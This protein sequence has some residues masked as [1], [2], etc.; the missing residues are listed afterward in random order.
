[1]PPCRHMSHSLK[2]LLQNDIQIQSAQSEKKWKWK[3]NKMRRI[4]QCHSTQ[5]IQFLWL[6][7]YNPQ[8]RARCWKQTVHKLISQGAW[9]H[10]TDIQSH[11]GIQTLI[12][13]FINSPPHCATPL[14]L[15]TFAFLAPL[16]HRGGPTSRISFQQIL[17]VVIGC[18]HS[19]VSFGPNAVCSLSLH[20][21]LFLKIKRRE[22]MCFSQQFCSP[23]RSE[24]AN[25]NIS[26]CV[27]LSSCERQTDTK[28][29]NLEEQSIC[30]FN[31]VIDGFIADRSVFPSAF[32]V[33]ITLHWLPKLLASHMDEWL[34][35]WLLHTRHNMRAVSTLSLHICGA[36]ASSEM[37]QEKGDIQLLQTI[38]VP[39]ELQWWRFQRSSSMRR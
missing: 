1:M 11:A 27:D 39:K 23:C 37:G 38:E 22:K 5:L 15:Q 14:P 3:L 20:L 35:H 24:W 30:S 12:N 33:L 17:K 34:L 28:T 26:N 19:W 32:V 18:S 8:Q 29:K 2:K 7:V 21:S 13:L 25:W 36:T 10:P 16:P 6:N 4:E 31:L 9:T